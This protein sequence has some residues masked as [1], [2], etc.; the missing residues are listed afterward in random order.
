MKKLLNVISKNIWPIPLV[1][2]L[3]TTSIIKV[4]E[5]TG[6]NYPFTMDQGR[7]MVDIRHMVV[8]FSPRLVGPTTSIN[9]VL[10]GPFWYYFNLIPFILSG[11]NPSAIVY[12]QI[13]WYQI[14]VIVLWLVLKKKS[15]SLAGITALFLFLMPTG[16]NTARYFW[17]ANSMPF[18]TIFFFAVLV[19][20][21]RHKSD[22]N[23]LLLGLVAGLALQIEA[24]F[25]ILLF[26]FAL[27]YLLFDKTNIKKLLNLIIGFTITLLPQALFELKHGFIMT[28]LLIGEVTGKGTMLGEK[29]SLSDKLLQR[30]DHFQLLVFR[31]S[32]LPPNYL[33]YLFIIGLII[34]LF[35]L[36]TL[37]EKSKTD[38]F[39]VWSVSFYFILFAAVFYLLFPQSLKIWYTLGL[40]IPIVIFFASFVNFL[41]ESKTP[42]I[43]V[44]A[45][46]LVGLTIYYSLKSQIDYTRDV[47]FKPSDDRSNMRN[48]L[49]AIDWVYQNAAGK[50]FKVYSYLPSVYDFPYNH[51][52]WWYGT[53]TFGYQPADVAYL[54]NQ[55]E[56]I[57]DVDKLWTKKRSVGENNL[58]FLII[59]EDFDMPQ[60][61]AAWLGN[62]SKL[63]LVKEVIFPWHAKVQMMAQCSR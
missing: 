28:K 11:G 5:V 60:R 43:K 1:I 19:A 63:C 22:R 48:E 24:A 17:N 21:I 49:R 42:V 2:I 50:G 7:D 8:T 27:I 34:F 55:P 44:F 3:V 16:F 46:C 25:G 61:T 38:E 56:Y 4:A 31:S 36:L 53:K 33:P 57:K 26:P 40:S 30:W 18:F 20:A 47:A 35:I 12:W 10:L 52:F 9:G 41:F 37:R 15:V 23:T 14:S 32:H 13:L 6:G 59:E 62:F 54:P 39:A 29:I 51:L 45:L 58:T